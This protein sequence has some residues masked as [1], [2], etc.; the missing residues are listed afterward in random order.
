[1]PKMLPYYW[2]KSEHVRRSVGAKKQAA[3]ALPRLAR[4][5]ESSARGRIIWVVEVHSGAAA[6][7]G[8]GHGGK[9]SMG[10]ANLAV[11]K[12]WSEGHPRKLARKSRCANSG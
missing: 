1:M 4:L 12:R 3:A 2:G 10:T 9:A 7:C 8:F 11:N 5:Q 6:Q